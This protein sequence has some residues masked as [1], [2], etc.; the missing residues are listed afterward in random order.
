VQKLLPWI[1]RTLV[2]EREEVRIE[3][4]LKPAH[5]KSLLC[6]KHR[7]IDVIVGSVAKENTGLVS[8]TKPEIRAM[9]F[10]E[11]PDSIAPYRRKS[12]VVWR[13]TVSCLKDGLC[14]LIDS[15]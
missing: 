8:E 9:L 4:N 10:L 12:I 2:G 13:L 11:E 7:A 1:I 15:G 6:E 14:R 3:S 5:H